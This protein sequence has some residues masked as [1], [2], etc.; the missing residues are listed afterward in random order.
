MTPDRVPVWRVL[1][2]GAGLVTWALLAHWGS[3][4]AGSPDFN[5]LVAVLPLL[6]VGALALHRFRRRWL[7]LSGGL[8][9][10]GL[11]LLYW[12]QLRSNVALL[13]YLQHLGIHMALAFWFGSTLTAPGDALVTRM[14]RLIEGMDLSALKVRYTRGVTVAWT[15]FFVLN[16]LVSTALFVFAPVAVWSFHANL[17]TGPLVGL[18]FLVEYLVRRRL[19]PAHE[20]PSLPALIHGYRQQ[21][22]ARAAPPAQ[23]ARK[24]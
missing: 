19:L 12:D 8:L 22:A 16:A 14:A 23:V 15:A 3:S 2:S 11:V 7:T 5:A 21:A 4:G 9:A 18:V 24:P 1:L 20:R 6:V 17:M 13:Y 10:S